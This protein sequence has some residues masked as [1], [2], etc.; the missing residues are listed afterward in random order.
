MKSPN[1]IPLQFDLDPWIELLVSR[2]TAKVELLIS[3][4]PSSTRRLLDVKQAAHYLGRS[5]ASIQH[6]AADGAFP[7]VRRDRR[8]FFDIRDLDA[9]IDKSKC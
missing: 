6:L 2:I 1:L 7:T 4:S 8:V 9:W 5:V 3:A